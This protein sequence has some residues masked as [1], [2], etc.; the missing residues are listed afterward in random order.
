MEIAVRVGEHDKLG[1]ECLDRVRFAVQELHDW[2]Q[3]VPTAGV[4][5]RQGAGVD[6]ADADAVGTHL[7]PPTRCL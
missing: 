5:G 4:P 1:T 7:S 6:V 2:P 3:A